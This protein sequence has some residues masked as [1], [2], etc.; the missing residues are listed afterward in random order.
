MTV[1]IATTF[2][3]NEDLH[4]AEEITSSALLELSDSLNVKTKVEGST[5]ELCFSM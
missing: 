4:I 5:I 2:L 3:D 1:R